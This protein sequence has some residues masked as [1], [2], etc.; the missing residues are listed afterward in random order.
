MKKKKGKS[1]F[2]LLLLDWLVV[3]SACLTA[4]YFHLQVHQNFPWR[5]L[6]PLAVFSFAIP[7]AVLWLKTI[8]WKGDTGFVAAVFLLCGLGIVTQ[9]RLSGF[10]ENPMPIKALIP[11]PAGLLAFLIGAAITG[12]RRGKWLSSA[13][14]LAYSAALGVILLMLVFGRSYRGAVYLPGR[15]NPSEILK[16]LLVLFMAAFLASRTKE[17][18]ETQI[19]IPV[20]PVSALIKLAFF[21]AVPVTGTILL[22]DLGLVVI[23]NAILVVMLFAVKRRFG[24]LVFGGFG[25]VA[26][27]Y[28]VQ[29]ISANAKGRFDV[30]L[31]PFTDPTGKGYQVLQSL[32]AMFSGG[33]WG[34]GIGGGD[35][36]Y[37]PIAE[38]DFVYA[39]L[40]E[41]IGFFGCLLLLLV[42]AVLFVRGFRAAGLI[43]APFERLLCVGLTASLAIQTVLNIA[44]VTKTLPMTG[45]TLPLI[46]HG[47]SSLIVTLLV[48]GVI[49]GLSDSKK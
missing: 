12:G 8:S 14:W 4:V 48:T 7:V 43:K 38:S 41:E 11:L 46:S 35:P 31:Y 47:G 30:W 37:V 18:S 27:G 24:Y 2:T 19:G 15:I 10:T 17:F 39:A 6:L 44:G 33:M 21:W 29:L 28:G 32:C 26:A 1:L 16:P 5:S 9:L 3:A 25:V 42:Y 23:L 40:A 36:R 49:A 34:S 22:K 13:G 20:P 45:I